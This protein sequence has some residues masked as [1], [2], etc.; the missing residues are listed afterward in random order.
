MSDA[1]VST[2]AATDSAI[3]PTSPEYLDDPRYDSSRKQWARAHMGESPAEE[4]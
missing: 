1:E 2:T 3:D 4:T